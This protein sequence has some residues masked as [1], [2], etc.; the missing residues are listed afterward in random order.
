MR[1]KGYALA[2]IL[3]LLGVAMFGVGAL[4]TISAL[5]SKISR[6][7][8]ESVTAYYVTE[9]GVEDAVWRINNTPAYSN[10]LASGT[11][12]ATYTTTNI[13]ATNQGYK[14]TMKSSAT[15]GAGYATIDVVGTDNNGIFTSTRHITTTVFQGTSGA[16]VG[17][18]ALLTGGSLSVV[19]GNK[20]ISF[21]G[22]DLFADSWIAFTSTGV[23]MNGG[24]IR[25]PGQY[26]AT[27]T[28]LTNLGGMYA[29]NCNPPPGS[30]CKAPPSAITPPAF[31]FV[32]AQANASVT[33]TSAQFLTLLKNGGSTINLPGPITYVSGDVNFDSSTKNKTLNITGEL[34]VKGNMSANNSASS[35]IVNVADPGTG[36]AGILISGAGNFSIGTWT[37]NGVLYTGGA[38]NFVSSQQFTVGGALI[39][40]G[41][42]SVNP[43]LGLAV[44]Y[45]ATRVNATFDGSVAQALQTQYWEEDY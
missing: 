19:N 11:L 28:N 21:S 34:V 29:L 23:N 43:G 10:A 37:V 3:V 1:K 24:S 22:G 5:E 32:A 27:N 25:T 35:L 4:V 20:T 36:K 9:A 42:I 18:P 13:P 41:S 12:N 33:Y 39:A 45:N 7:Q 2:T 26:S 15:L 6:S 8:L 31:D 44:T 38:M 14:V 40:G 16:P 30:G 17:T